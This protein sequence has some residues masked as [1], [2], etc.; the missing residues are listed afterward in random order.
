MANISRIDVRLKTG[1]SGGAGTDGDVYIGVAGREFHIDSAYNDFERNSDRTYTLGRGA[2]VKNAAFNNPRDPQLDTADLSIFPEYLRFEPRGSGPNW[3]LEY[4]RI[5]VNPGPSQISY[6][7]LL[8]SP[9]LWLGQKY[10]KI[11][12]LKKV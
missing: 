10:G 1:S 8:G 5:T 3:N 7:S 4:V 2:N 6:R 11:V 12:Y 9:D